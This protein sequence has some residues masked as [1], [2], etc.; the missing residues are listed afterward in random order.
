MARWT[1]I[2]FVSPLVVYGQCLPVDKI[3]QDELHTEDHVSVSSPPVA[4]DARLLAAPGR[5][6]RPGRRRPGAD[7]HAARVPH[8]PP[9]KDRYVKQC[10]M[11]PIPENPRSGVG[12][13]GA[14]SSGRLG[15]KMRLNGWPGRNGAGSR[16]SRPRLNRMARECHETAFRGR[17]SP[18]SIVGARKFP[19]WREYE[20]KRAQAWHADGAGCRPVR[21]P[22]GH[23]I[24]HS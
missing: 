18:P 7:L 1:S 21:Q 24:S 23:A 5:S 15:A 16:D 12:V 20:P 11:L 6:H 14:E 2:H 19:A 10:R 13:E 22:A 4:F 3:T 17:Q 9:A 8:T